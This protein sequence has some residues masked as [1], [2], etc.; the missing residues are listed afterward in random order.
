M[1]LMY[2]VRAS[3]NTSL[4]SLNPRT[5]TH[6]SRRV[7]VVGGSLVMV[8][9]SNLRVGCQ[10]GISGEN[11]V[12]VQESSGLACFLLFRWSDGCGPPG[13]ILH[14]QLLGL[15]DRPDRQV[16]QY[17]PAGQTSQCRS[18]RGAAK[19]PLQC[20]CSTRISPR[21]LRGAGLIASRGPQPSQEL[22]DIRIAVY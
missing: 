10:Q 14:H 7:A 1:I 19:Y 16:T 15:W 13:G 21:G 6:K 5:N 22:W 17:S 8:D 2:F 3:I 20:I 9:C 12:P 11:I 18:F 4:C